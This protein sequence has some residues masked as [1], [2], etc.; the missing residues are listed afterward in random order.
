MTLQVVMEGIVLVR[1]VGLFGLE[2][3]RSDE[4]KMPN[5]KKPGLDGLVFFCFVRAVL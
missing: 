3:L 2:R 4:T 1:I 5:T